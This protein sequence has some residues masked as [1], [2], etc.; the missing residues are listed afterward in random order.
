MKLE[1]WNPLIF[2]GS[3]VS[4]SEFLSAAAADAAES[5]ERGRGATP[6]PILGSLETTGLTRRDVS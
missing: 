1:K 3:K 6:Q 5:M 2:L 4:S